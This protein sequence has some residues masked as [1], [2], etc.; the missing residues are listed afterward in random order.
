MDDMLSTPDPL[1]YI[2]LAPQAWERV[3]HFATVVVEED[4]HL[5]VLH[6]KSATQRVILPCCAYC[7]LPLAFIP[8]MTFSGGPM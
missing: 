5:V 3:C 8:I 6:A 4:A 1:H 2:I 7:N